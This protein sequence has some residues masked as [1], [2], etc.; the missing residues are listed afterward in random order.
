VQVSRRCLAIAEAGL[1]PKHVEVAEELSHLGSLL[2]QTNDLA[3]ADTVL[4]RCLHIRE[5]VC[6]HPFALLVSLTSDASPSVACA[7]QG[8]T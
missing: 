3:G 1:G 2:R 6:V 4:S 5:M 8:L 7:F